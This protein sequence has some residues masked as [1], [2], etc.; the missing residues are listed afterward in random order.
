MKDRDPGLDYWMTGVQFGQTRGS[1]IQEL[2]DLM[3]AEYQERVWFKARENSVGDP[4]L[5]FFNNIMFSYELI[6]EELNLEDFLEEKKPPYEIIG[7]TLKNEKEAESL[8]Q[9]AN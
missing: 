5:S 3:D 6:I 2:L 7:G 8:Y 1:L 9:V 4:S